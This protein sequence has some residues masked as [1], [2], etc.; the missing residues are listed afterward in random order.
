MRSFER[1]WTAAASSTIAWAWLSPCCACDRIIGTI[2]GDT[3]GGRTPCSIML[4]VW[5][6]VDTTFSAWSS[7]ISVPSHTA[8]S[9]R[10]RRFAMTR[11]FFA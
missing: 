4:T 5:V 11:G 9:R 8:F 7:C 2:M 6:I 3:P 1:F 10:S